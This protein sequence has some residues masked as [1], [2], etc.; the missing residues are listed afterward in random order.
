MEFVFFSSRGRA[1][2]S[3]LR[4]DPRS[5]ERFYFYDCSCLST[6]LLLSE[7]PLGRSQEDLNFPTCFFFLFAEF[8]CCEQVLDLQTV[9]SGETD[10]E[11]PPR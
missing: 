3:V 4:F 8:L 5:P 6:L 9:S 1:G 2:L 10:R 7:G 11:R